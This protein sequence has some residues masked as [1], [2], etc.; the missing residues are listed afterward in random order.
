MLVIR[1]SEAP[2]FV[3]IPVPCYCDSTKIQIIHVCYSSISHF[4]NDNITYS[5]GN[6]SIHCR[7]NM[8]SK[9]ICRVMVKALKNLENATD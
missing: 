5:A 2:G 4:S 8:T 3:E 6:E 1:P 7:L 9:E